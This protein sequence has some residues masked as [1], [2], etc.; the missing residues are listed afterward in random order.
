MSAVAMVDGISY[1]NGPVVPPLTTRE[2]AMRL[3]REHIALRLVDEGGMRFTGDLVRVDEMSREDAWFMRRLGGEIFELW[4]RCRLYNPV[5]PR[6]CGE[7]ILREIEAKEAKWVAEGSPPPLS[8]GSVTGVW[9]RE[10]W[11]P[12]DT[13]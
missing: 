8:D 3:A 13:H 5:G 7:R 9:R 12:E 4:A 2:R 6:P 1:Y 10:E 11:V